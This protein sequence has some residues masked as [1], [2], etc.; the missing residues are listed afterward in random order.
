MPYEILVTKQAVKDIKL[1]TPKLKVKAKAVLTELIGV[2]P[3]IG[4]PLVGDLKGNYSYRL[5][6]K[7]RL[8]YSIDEE[9]KKVYLKRART[10]YGG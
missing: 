6:I 4:K 5:N 8:V 10:H 7:D 2:N 3:Y 9:H 1:L